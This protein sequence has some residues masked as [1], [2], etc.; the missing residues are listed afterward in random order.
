MNDL[1]G[2]TLIA[3]FSASLAF[4]FGFFSPTVLKS[5]ILGAQYCVYVP[6]ENKNAL[7][8]D[9]EGR[10]QV[11]A[12]VGPGN[13]RLILR[14]GV[15]KYYITGHDNYETKNLGTAMGIKYIA[16]GIHISEDQKL[17]VSRT[18]ASTYVVQKA[19]WS[20]SLIN[21]S[22]FDLLEASITCAK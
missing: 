9:E 17:L 13:Y 22:G 7:G 12:S 5:S 15:G 8:T 3:T 16:N 20:N 2:K 6:H 21:P 1:F 11:V 10:I 4:I 19:G 18:Y 14:Q